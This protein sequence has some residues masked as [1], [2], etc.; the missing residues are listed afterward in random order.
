MAPLAPYLCVYT[1]CKDE[2]LKDKHTIMK[3][4]KK[5]HFVS[6]SL[7]NLLQQCGAARQAK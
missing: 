7:I 1:A 3:S 4:T 6:Q 2:I 5:K